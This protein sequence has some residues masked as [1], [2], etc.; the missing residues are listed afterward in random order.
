MQKHEYDKGLFRLIDILTK[1]SKNELPT[2]KDLAKE[3]GVTI[4]TIQNDLN[5]RL[6]NYPIEKTTGHKYQFIDGFSLS[7][8]ALNTDEMILI[9]LALSQFSDVKD[10]D[11]ITNSTI[12]KL[13]STTFLSPYH[14]K[15][16]DLQNINIDSKLIQDIEDA[17]E[18]N[19]IVNVR[20][21]G[22]KKEVS[23]YKIVNIDGFWYLLAKD[24][25]DNKIKTYMISSISDIEVL[26]NKTCDNSNI[27]IPN[28]LDKVNSAYFQDGESYKVKIK[29]YSQIA[30]YF[31]EKE[32]LIS[33]EIVDEK[34]DGSLIVT[35]NVTH[36]EDVD[37]IIKSW[38]PHIEVL[39]PL[40]F[41]EKIKNELREYLNILS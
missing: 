6:I 27:N 25:T 17:I 4:R 9:S 3:Y 37:N 7:H 38:L 15:K 36:D 12:K 41:R 19:M 24:L 23:P 40:R 20:Y 8:S 28:I 31:R 26:H 33:Q 34:K 35:F 32:F 39:E 21:K 29:V 16:N 5:K 13:I 30:Y 14:M 22:N 10:F 2:T 1:L 11:K 18:L